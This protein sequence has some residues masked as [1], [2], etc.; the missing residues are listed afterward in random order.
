MTVLA[1]P[2]ET[3]SHT[4]EFGV[5]HPER[6]IDSHGIHVIR[7]PLRWDWL[8]R[9]WS[10]LGLYQGIER[11]LSEADPEVVFVH[12]PQFLDLRAVGRYCR[13]NPSTRLYIDNHADYYNSARNP[14][15]RMIL[16]RVIWRWE[17]RNVDRFVDRYW[18]ITEESCDFLVEVYGVSREKV[19]LLPLGATVEMLGVERREAIRARVRERLGLSEGDFVLVTG[20]KIDLRKRIHE[21]VELVRDL[22]REDVKLVVFGSVLSEL[23]DSFDQLVEDERIRYTGWADPLEMAEYLVAGDLAVFPGSQS[24]LWTQAVA[25]GTPCVF[26]RWQKGSPVDI[27]GNCHF[28]ETDDYDELFRVVRAIIESPG[29]YREMQLAAASPARQRFSYTTIAEQAISG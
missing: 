11:D 10:R 8:R 6:Y 7:E 15:S 2:F 29:V 3:E 26:R 19:G 21:V 17:L 22:R 23:R 25:G 9:S 12:G 16:H 20:G 24:V 13:A 28:L 14:L 5:Y 4:G 27:G 18:G 1:M